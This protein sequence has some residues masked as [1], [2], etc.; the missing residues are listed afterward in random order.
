MKSLIITGLVLLATLPGQSQIKNS[1]TAIVK[2]YGNCGM[3]EETIE[4]AAD[5]KKISQA[6]WNEETK[7]ATITYDNSKTNLNAILKKIALAGYDSQEFLALDDAYNKLPACCKYD[8]EK[9]TVAMVSVPVNNSSETKLN[10]NNHQ[11]EGMNNAVPDVNQLKAIFDSYFELKDAL[12]QTDAATASTKAK[13]MEKAI[14]RVKM[15]LLNHKVHMVWMKVVKGLKDDVI[16]I[17]NSTDIALQR[18]HFISLS[19]SMY[20][21]AKIS[22][23]GETVYYQ[24][25]PM[26]NDGNGAN[27]LSKENGIKNPYYGSRM[28]TCGKTVE[29]IKP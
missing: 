24:H 19:E 26:A 20:Q 15:D 6:D 29:T 10:Q 23:P 12:A 4:K 28:L 7:M 14:E 11:H 22:K 18:K 3:C 13:N 16:S 8:R 1:T 25:C 9:K 21:L 17:S 2:V 5:Q 27:W